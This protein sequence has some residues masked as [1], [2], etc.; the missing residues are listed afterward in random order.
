MN[1]L[2]IIILALAV[3]A[4]FLFIL[5]RNVGRVWLDHAIRLSLLERIE[6][7]PELLDQVHGVLALLNEPH[8]ARLP[9]QDY[10]VTGFLLALIG[11]AC[12]VTGRIVRT[13][14]TA[15][16]VYVGG[17]LCIG[18]AILLFFVGV[19]IRR[20]SRARVIKAPTR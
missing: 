2:L 3:L 20:L 13:G 11:T 7:H 10:R 8:K 14:E 5:L 4:V 16:A 19:L 17:C 18:I 12:C 1:P 6:N 9:R 15:D